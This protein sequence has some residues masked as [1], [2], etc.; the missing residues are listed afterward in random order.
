[1]TLATMEDVL[2]PQ[3]MLVRGV[4]HETPDMFT[5]TFDV[6][7]RPGGFHFLPGQFNMLSLHGIGEVPISISGDPARP[8]EL[9]H[10]IRS[11]GA[12]TRP[13]AAVKRGAVMGV[14]GPYGTGWPLDQA[15]GRDLILIA[16]GIGLAP[17]R[18]VIYEAVRRRGEFDRLI[19]L[20]G[21]RTPDDLLFGKELERW[22]GRFDTTLLVT[23]DRG[24]PDWHGYVGV[25]TSLLARV[26]F[27][28]YDSV[29]M[30]CGPEI[31]LRFT[32]RDLRTLGMAPERI[33]VSMERNM[34]CG[35]G[36]CGHCQL[37]PHFVCKD[38]PVFSLDRVARL[39]EI[40]EV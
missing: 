9:V 15:R 11:L 28:P 19:I 12:V 6:A 1:M 26:R 16:G 3:P 14:R 34:R 36:L 10:T 29:A 18:P 31:M 20:Y 37:G 17:L 8:T 30:L 23:T 7:D 5:I 33:F 39:L 38:G 21:A 2:L 32:V 27:D 13:M 40:R 22:R 25:V 24:R 35:V 4:H